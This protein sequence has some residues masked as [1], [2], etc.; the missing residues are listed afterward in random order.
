MAGFSPKSQNSGS[1]ENIGN[2]V[3]RPDLA[4]QANP[5]SVL[6]QEWSFEDFTDTL[7]SK[8]TENEFE[9]LELLNKPSPKR[10]DDG[11]TEEIVE[12]EPEKPDKD[13]VLETFYKF[14]RLSDEEN[15]S[16]GS[17]IESSSQEENKKVS[18]EYYESN[19]GDSVV[20]VVVSGN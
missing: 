6:F 10:L 16:E 3:E 8:E 15:D 1:G 9:E 13:E 12:I 7:L 5:C 14:F 18:V 20:G 17:K 2:D 11:S 4:N 19:P